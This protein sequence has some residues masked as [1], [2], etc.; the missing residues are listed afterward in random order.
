MEKEKLLARWHVLLNE[1]SN[2]IGIRGVLQ[3]RLIILHRLNELGENDI[4]GLSIIRALEETN[5]LVWKTD[6]R[7]SESLTGGFPVAETLSLM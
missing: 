6:R 1:S 2:A 5:D 7:L 4:E 3:E